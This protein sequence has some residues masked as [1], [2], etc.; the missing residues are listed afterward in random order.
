MTLCT[1]TRGIMERINNENLHDENN[2]F[3]EVFDGTVGE[4]LCRRGSPFLNIFLVLAEGTF[5]DLH[6][7]M[8]GLKRRDGESDT[9]FRNRILTEERIVQSTNDFLKLD[10]GLWVYF[11]RVVEDKNILTSRNPYL[12]QYHT[13]SYVFICSGSD[14]EYIRKKFLLEDIKWVK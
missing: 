1:Y 4:Y 5:L 12:K 9:S 14:S 11:P 2:P 7:D 3:V 6:G 10:I 8:F 13:G